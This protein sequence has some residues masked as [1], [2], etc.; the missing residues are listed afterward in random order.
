VRIFVFFLEIIPFSSSLIT[1]SPLLKFVVEVDIEE[2]AVLAV[3][4]I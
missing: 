3:S 2:D 1:S 4:E